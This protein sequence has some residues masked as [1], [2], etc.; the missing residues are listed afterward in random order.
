MP[1]VWNHY[2]ERYDIFEGVG[3]FAREFTMPQSVA[4]SEA[5]IA[6]LDRL[7][8]ASLGAGRRISIP[9]VKSVMGW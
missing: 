4:L 2:A 9:F 6:V 5:L 3:W 8:T 1:G 7:D